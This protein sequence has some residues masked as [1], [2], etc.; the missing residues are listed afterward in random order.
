MF[1]FVYRPVT[2]SSPYGEISYNYAEICLDR[3]TV[4][5]SGESFRSSRCNVSGIL[6][7]V[8]E[9]HDEELGKYNVA[10]F[11]IRKMSIK[12]T[13]LADNDENYQHAFY[14]HEGNS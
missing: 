6:R 11:F 12:L 14:L 3:R 13:K 5:N 2:K 10:M 1:H 7:P 4:K 8:D 9:T